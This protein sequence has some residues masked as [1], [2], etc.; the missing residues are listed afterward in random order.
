M[1]GVTTQRGSIGSGFAS[2]GTMGGVAA[3]AATVEVGA[4]GPEGAQKGFGKVETEL[5]TVWGSKGVDRLGSLGEGWCCLAGCGGCIVAVGR[6][7]PEEP[8]LKSQTLGPFLR[9]GGLKV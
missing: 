7:V 3:D 1:R 4:S 8:T 5:S 2:A 9:W 6:K